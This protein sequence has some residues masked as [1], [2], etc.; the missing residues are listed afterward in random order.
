MRP[1]EILVNEDESGRA[2]E[3]AHL[4]ALDV[5]GEHRVLVGFS[6]RE[7]AGLGLLPEGTTLRRY[8]LYLDLHDPA[9]AEFAAEG[10]ERVK[11]G[12]RLV[13]RDGA[14][15]EL[16]DALRRACSHVVGRRRAG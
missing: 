5:R 15:P 4:T 13:A 1:W 7:L 3:A 6:D 14:D 2:T 12:Q 16:W 11:P 10:A 8:R 9:R